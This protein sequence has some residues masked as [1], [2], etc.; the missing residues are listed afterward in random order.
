[1]LDYAVKWSI[2]ILVKY[3]LKNLNTEIFKC[4]M[5]ASSQ[6]TTPNHVPLNSQESISFDQFFSFFCAQSV[7]DL[8]PHHAKRWKHAFNRSWAAGNVAGSVVAGRICKNLEAAF[9]A[10]WLCFYQPPFPWFERRERGFKDSFWEEFFVFDFQG[11]QSR[12]KF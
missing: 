2:V 4:S 1:M 3:Q 5:L 11:E 6:F 10:W 9:P 7:P 12:K 8:R